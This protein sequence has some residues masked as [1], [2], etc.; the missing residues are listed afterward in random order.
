MVR[1]TFTQGVKYVADKAGA[2]WFLDKIAT[3]QMLPALKAELFQTWKL[4]VYDGQKGKIIC[5]DGDDQVLFEEIV[6]FTDFPK[7]GITLWF[8]DDTIL[9]PSEC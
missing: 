8:T 4:E 6:D 7:P 5:T 9:L 2:Y 3:N 1:I